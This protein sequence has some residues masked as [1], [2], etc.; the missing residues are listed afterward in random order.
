[1]TIR[2]TKTQYRTKRSTKW[3]ASEAAVEVPGLPKVVAAKGGKGRSLSDQAILS[4]YEEDMD[5]CVVRR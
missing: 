5:G 2:K 4:V 1:M 3:D